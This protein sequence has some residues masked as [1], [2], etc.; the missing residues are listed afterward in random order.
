[1]QLLQRPARVTDQPEG[2]RIP[3]PDLRLV[4]VYLDQF[5]T[6]HGGQPDPG[7]DGQH[8]VAFSHSGLG[9]HA[10]A[11]QRKVVF[12]GDGAPALS[13]AEH[14]R[15]KELGDAHKRFACARRDCAAAG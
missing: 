12:V 6:E 1:V 10:A 7:A 3:A 4:D 5:L 15:L 8:Q 2:V 11:P 9:A 13:R 14:R